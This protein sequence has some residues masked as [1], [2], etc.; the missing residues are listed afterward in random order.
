MPASPNRLPGALRPLRPPE[1]PASDACL[2][3]RFVHRRDEEA[4]AAV[5][6]RHGPAVLRVCRRI[7]GAGPPAEDAFQATF[8]VLVRR[9]AS[10][11]PDGALGGWLCGVARRVA[12]KVARR[13]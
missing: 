13:Q 6:R 10:V 8:L 1:E 2:L 4:F 7:L 11:R 3:E 12:L 5:V 9:A